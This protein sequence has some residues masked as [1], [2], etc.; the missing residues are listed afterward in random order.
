MNCVV[1]FI[2]LMQIFVNLVTWRSPF[3]GHIRYS[4]WHL[5]AIN[6]KLSLTYQFYYYVLTA[7]AL[8]YCMYGFLLS[9][10]LQVT[11][12]ETDLF[13]VGLGF[14][15]LSM[16]LTLTFEDFRRCLRNPWTVCFC[17]LAACICIEILTQ[18]C[19]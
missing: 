15:M 14:L 9:L 3:A 5:Q 13:T 8:T 11:W 1:S 7:N 4:Y 10:D 18:F 12:L 16:G 19:T 2:N 6:G 17:P